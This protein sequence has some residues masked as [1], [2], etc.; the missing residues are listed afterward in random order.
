MLSPD[1]PLYSFPGASFLLPS[2]SRSLIPFILS[3]LH[4]Y[5][6]FLYPSLPFSISPSLPTS[7]FLFPSCMPPF[8]YV[9]IITFLCSFFHAPNLFNFHHPSPFALLS[10]VHLSPFFPPT[11]TLTSSLHSPFQPPFP[12]FFPPFALT[13]LPFLSPRSEEH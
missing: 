6:S 2:I 3:S 10:S 12:G 5:P 9:F 8:I 1:Y 11:F 7:L 4:L 13:S